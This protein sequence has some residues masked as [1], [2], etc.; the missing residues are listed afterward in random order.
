MK[1]Q[2]STHAFS[3]LVE[4]Q[5]KG[6]GYY[7]QRYYKL[8]V[9][10]T[11]QSI[12]DYFSAESMAQEAFLR[13][14]LNRANI[15]KEDDVLTFLQC[16]MRA[17]V[18]RYFKSAKEH[19]HQGM[20]L[21]DPVNNYPAFHL[22]RMLDE[23][24]ADRPSVSVAEERLQ[25]AQLKQI[26]AF[27]PNLNPEHQQLL[28]LCM[29]YNFQYEAIAEQLGG[30]SDYQVAYKIEKLLAFL[31]KVFTSGQQMN[32]LERLPKLRYEGDL[33]K[34]QLLIFQLR[35]EAKQSF[36]EIAKILALH[37]STVKRQFV[38]AHAKNLTRHVEVLL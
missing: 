1:K 34:Q 31:R 26:R 6:L 10:R 17:A 4:G 11:A 3:Q 29:H 37:V 33:D 30:V 21:F 22:H 13:L 15:Q 14:W 5:E 38:Q 16:V 8:L 36:E 20:L 18:H 27:I 32:S 9:Y 25:Q 7:Y 24:P 12:K 35:Y 28:Q 2:K 19:F 23:E